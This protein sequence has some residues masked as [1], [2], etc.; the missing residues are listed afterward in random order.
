MG[1]YF[2]SARNCIYSEVRVRRV[3][4]YFKSVCNFI[5]SEVQIKLIGEYFELARNR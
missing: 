1:E 4:E 2:K 3:R 5:R